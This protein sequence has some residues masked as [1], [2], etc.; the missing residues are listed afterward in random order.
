MSPET[1]PFTNFAAA[2]AETVT[3]PSCR[4]ELVPGM[5]FCRLCGF[6]LGEGIA[7][8]TET[9]RLNSM[10]TMSPVR[11]G[12]Q[13]AGAR[14]GSAWGVAPAATAAPLVSK[15]GR[16]C[17]GSGAG[18]MMWVV[19]AIVL[20]SAGGIGM[21]KRIGA[22]RQGVTVSAPATPRSFFGTENFDYVEGKGVLVE[23]V[24]PGGPAE[25]AGLR[26]GDFIQ[27]F[28]GRALNSAD[29][30]RSLLRSTPPGRTVPVTFLRDGAMMSVMLTTIA[31]DAYD[32]KAFLPPNGSGYWG[33][34]NYKR[35]EVPGENI[36]GVR[37]G[38]VS[39]NRPADIAGLQR[40]D[41]VIEFNGDPVRTAEGLESYINHAAP[42]TTVNVVV[43]RDGQRLELPVRMGKD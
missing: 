31:A 15:R 2:S 20:S 43:I 34:S 33:I 36:Y 7:E 37:L 6:R 24:L 12:P 38:S 3:C 19:I 9:V 5:R 4:A 27:Q 22:F 28:N 39:E 17:A 30:M 8:Y 1:Q 42:G 16:V 29:D 23:S 26:D 41:I 40:G 13:T 10:P 14:G 25:R 18:W 11:P 32:P 21:L 35:V